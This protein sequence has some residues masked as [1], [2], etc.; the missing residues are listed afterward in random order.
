[1]GYGR[2]IGSFMCG[3]EVVLDKLDGNGP[4]EQPIMSAIHSPHASLA[5]WPLDYS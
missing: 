2:R 4:I 5:E 3:R 1:M